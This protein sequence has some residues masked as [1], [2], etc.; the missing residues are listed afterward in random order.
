MP[1]FFARNHIFCRLPQSA[2]VWPRPAS[3]VQLQRVCQMP[4]VKN[5][6]EPGINAL[7]RD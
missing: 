7:M 5:G 2:G 6:V 4:A 3:I 1:A